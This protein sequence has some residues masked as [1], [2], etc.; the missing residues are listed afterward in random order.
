MLQKLKR[1]LKSHR[2]SSSRTINDTLPLKSDVTNIAIVGDHANEVVLGDYSADM[3]QMKS[4][5]VTPL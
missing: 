3:D 4:E 1:R 5:L 2:V